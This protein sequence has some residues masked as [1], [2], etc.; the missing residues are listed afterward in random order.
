MEAPAALQM[1]KYSFRRGWSLNFTEGTR[2]KD[3]LELMEIPIQ[4]R[5]D[6]WAMEMTIL[7]LETCHIYLFSYTTARV[8]AEAVE[9]Y[10]PRTCGIGVS[11][12]TVTWASTVS[13]TEYRWNENKKCIR[14]TGLQKTAVPCTF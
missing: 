13:C 5:A 10:T 8:P 6:C 1:L 2:R 3:K 11:Q 12:V 14:L 4:V 7:T 9:V